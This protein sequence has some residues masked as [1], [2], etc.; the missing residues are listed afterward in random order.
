MINDFF[1]STSKLAIAF[2]ITSSLVLSGCGG[3]GGS[4]SGGGGGGGT[5]AVTVSVSPAVITVGTAQTQSFSATVGNSSNTSVTWSVQGSS[6]GSIAGDGTYT[7]PTAAGTYH[8]VATSVA[9]SSKSATATVTVVAVGVA[10]APGTQSLGINGTHTFTATISNA[11]NTGVTWSVQEGAAGGTIDGAGVYTAPNQA[12]T[13]HIVAR[14][15]ADNTKTGSA[16]VTVTAPAPV[17]TS[18]P[19]AS[20]SAAEGVQSSYTVAATDPAGGTIS[21]SVAGPSGASISGNVLTWTPSGAQARTA[22]VFTVTATTSEGGTGTQSFSLTPSGTIHGNRQFTYHTTDSSGAFHSNNVPDDTSLYSIVAYVPDGS[23]GFTSHAGTGAADG[24]Y[25]IPGIPAGY[26]WLQHG[27]NYFW[28]NTSNIDTGYDWNGRYNPATAGASTTLALSLSSASPWQTSDAGYLFA[29]NT[30]SYMP[31][32]MSAGSPDINTSL[33][34]SFRSQLDSTMGDSL[35]VYQMV[36]HSVTG[37]G[38][39]ATERFYGPQGYTITSGIANSLSG[40]L[41]TVTANSSVRGYVKGSQFES[42][43]QTGQMGQNVTNDST[44]TGI[45]ALPAP[46]NVGFTS[47][48]GDL[49]LTDDCNTSSPALTDLDLGAI[50][51]GNPYPANWPIFAEYTHRVHTNY[52]LA[53]TT[54]PYSVY[55]YNIVYTTNLPTSNS[56]ITPMVGPVQNPTIKAYGSSSSSSLLA[57]ASGVGLNPVI[58]WQAPTIGTPNQY[59]VWIGQLGTFT[60]LTTLTNYTTLYV[61]GNVTSIQV[62]PGF[63]TAGNTYVVRISARTVGS[64]NVEQ[65]PYRLALPYGNSDVL[66]GMITP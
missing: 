17:F 6:S 11:S 53:G 15:T 49:I 62:P 9:D 21:Y 65:T 44:C 24:S 26:Y 40:S 28:T 25:S 8:V 30:G 32:N 4:T 59:L 16:A 13:Y 42:L 2:F 14:S 66:S 29:P 64:V 63:M 33:N 47:Y 1:R 45:Q 10:V 18:T 27:I 39:K 52:L 31:F 38:Y 37:G 57:D 20:T 22:N 56:P 35:F 12:G 34:F 3:G 19:P 7:A 48:S 60:T 41:V 50:S 55:G 61:S 54:T 43:R 51:Y 36:H 23:G 5:P 58:S 46:A